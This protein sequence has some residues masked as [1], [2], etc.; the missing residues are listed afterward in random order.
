[1]DIVSYLLGK[2]GQYNGQDTA[3]YLLGKNAGGGG[4]TCETLMLLHYDGDYTDFSEYHRVPTF[5][6]GSIVYGEGKFDR[7]FDWTTSGRA[8]FTYDTLYDLILDDFTIDFWI[9][10]TYFSGSNAAAGRPILGNYIKNNWSLVWEVFVS[11]YRGNIRKWGFRYAQLGD[12]FRLTGNTE[13]KQ[14]EWQHLAVT[15]DKAN[16]K[17]VLYLN[18]IKDG[19]ITNSFDMVNPDTQIYKFSIGS[20]FDS[21]YY[22]YSNIDEIRIS[23]G[24]RYTENF[25]PPTEPY[26]S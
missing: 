16:R 11:E 14:N 18:G 2:K 8:I 22:C 17:M 10:P 25:T 4:D 26:T 21:N 9:Y 19:E 15:Y 24:I 3:S 7:S 13:L 1:M 5:K 12:E 20:W 6:T 23:K